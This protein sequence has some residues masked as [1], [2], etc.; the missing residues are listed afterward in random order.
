MKKEKKKDDDLLWDI[1]NEDEEDNDDNDDTVQDEEEYLEIP[2]AGDEDNTEKDLP[3]EKPAAKRKSRKS[4][5]YPPAVAMSEVLKYC[6]AFTIPVFICINAPIQKAEWQKQFKDDF[7]KSAIDIMDSVKHISLEELQGDER[8]IEP[9]KNA[10]SAFVKECGKHNVGY[11]Y[12]AIFGKK[13]VCDTESAREVLKKGE[14]THI[15]RPEFFSSGLFKKSKE[16]IRRDP[17]KEIILMR[18]GLKR[19][20]PVIYVE[21]LI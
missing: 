2:D 10:L 13:I 17:I 15:W 3:E 4:K 9:L 1:D 8:Y 12:C 19:E 20:P 11:F 16:G 14:G 5:A 6:A 18:A 21:D 7:A